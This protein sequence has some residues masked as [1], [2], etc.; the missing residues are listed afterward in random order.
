MKNLGAVR[1]KRVSLFGFALTFFT[2]H[3]ARIVTKMVQTPADIS[4]SV[5]IRRHQLGSDLQFH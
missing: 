5:K 2:E 3:M 1:H 4:F